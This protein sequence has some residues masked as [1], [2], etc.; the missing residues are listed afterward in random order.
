ML[1]ND[2]ETI[3]DLRATMVRF[4]FLYPPSHTQ[5]IR[6]RLLARSKKQEISLFVPRAALQ[7]EDRNFASVIGDL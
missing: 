4:I 5:C 7:I 3:V 6:Q 1:V 2:R